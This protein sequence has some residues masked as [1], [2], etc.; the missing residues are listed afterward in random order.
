MCRAVVAGPRSDLESVEPFCRSG[1]SYVPL[2]TPLPDVDVDTAHESRLSNKLS[3][4]MNRLP[5]AYHSSLLSTFDL[6]SF[7]RYAAIVT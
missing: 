6:A 1:A 4:P 5:L 7:V 2:L 3:L